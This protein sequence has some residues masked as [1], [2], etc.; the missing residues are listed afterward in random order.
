[1][2][3][4][5]RLEKWR[6]YIRHVAKKACRGWVFSGQED[7]EQTLTIALWKCHERYGDFTEQ[8][9]HKAYYVA[10]QRALISLFRRHKHKNQLEEVSLETAR[11]GGCSNGLRT[12]GDDPFVV[13]SLTTKH[14]SG[15]FYRAKIRE[16]IDSVSPE[17][18]SSVLSKIDQGPPP[19]RSPVE[20]H[21][22]SVRDQNAFDEV[23]ELVRG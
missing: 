14:V 21:A 17:G 13:D 1:M 23:R 16:I 9:F 15:E 19:R 2:N 10:V 7:V 22:A 8:R 5:A 18:L 6:R 3:F 20:R 11:K 4:D 12:K